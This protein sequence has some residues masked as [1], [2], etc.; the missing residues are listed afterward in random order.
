MKKFRVHHI[1][2]VPKVA[3]LLLQD[4]S[5]LCATDIYGIHFCLS[6]SVRNIL[7][8]PNDRRSISRSSLI[9]HTCS[10]REK[11]I[12]CVYIYMDGK[13]CQNKTPYS[14]THSPLITTKHLRKIRRLGYI[15]FLHFLLYV[16]SLK[17]VF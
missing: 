17:K 15:W 3:I 6:L 13:I 16:N 14:H 8:R 9:K 4:L 7:I 2:H 11:F 12:V 10:W 1:H 5:T